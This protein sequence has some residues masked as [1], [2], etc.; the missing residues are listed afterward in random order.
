MLQLVLNECWQPKQN[1]YVLLVS[2]SGAGKTPAGGMCLGKLAKMEKDEK[3]EYD[4]KTTERL[5]NLKRKRSQDIFNDSEQDEDH[6]EV[7]KRSQQYEGL[8]EEAKMFHCKTRV[9][10]SITPEALTLT[11][12]YGSSNIVVK[13]DEF[14]VL[15]LMLL[16]L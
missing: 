9:V 13:W 8:L 7:N 1:L 6:P 15:T 2:Y 11:L 10:E 5:K 4:E 14:K 16:Y 3:I 12:F